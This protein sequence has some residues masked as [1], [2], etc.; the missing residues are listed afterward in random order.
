MDKRNK[1]YMR[2]EALSD[3]DLLV[4]KLYEESAEPVAWDESDDAVLAM[5]H[6]IHETDAASAP[7]VVDMPRQDDAP[8]PEASGPDGTAE[9]EDDG[10]STVVAFAPRK[11][12]PS[13]WSVF[14]SPLA[15]LAVAASLMIGVFSG[16]GLMPY[17]NLGVAPDQRSGTT[18]ATRSIRI[19]DPLAEPATAVPAATLQVKLEELH[20][21]LGGYSCA[22]LSVTLTARDQIKVAGV[23]SS[24]DQLE[25]LRTELAQITEVQDIDQSVL[26]HG[27]PICRALEILGKR[28][29]A[30]GAGAQGPLVLPKDHAAIYQGGDAMVIEALARQHYQGYL[31]VDFL[32]N[33]GQVVHL[34]PHQ[35]RADN[36]IKPGHRVVMGDRGQRYEIGAPFG[37]DMLVA[38][39][40][41][42]P[43]FDELRP[44]V[45]PADAYFDALDL[46]LE[47]ANSQG[48]GRDLFSGYSF[49]KTHAP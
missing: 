43:L 4:L 41:P 14:R 3:A 17:V 34:L 19:T 25:R 5:A 10:E 2:E 24:V 44:Q 35:G 37:T 27:W 36:L 31:Y 12:A 13:G 49:I 32:Q 47:Q 46:A 38:I 45:E 28:T 7:S 21:L 8:A 30:D 29:V 26:V 48:Y 6:S 20:G 40:S 9:A 11:K 33:D 22:D 23:V 39:V 15:G 1:S 16:Q 42:V 18:S